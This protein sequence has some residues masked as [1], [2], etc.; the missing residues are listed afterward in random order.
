MFASFVKL[1]YLFNSKWLHLFCSIYYFEC[2]S[3]II[4]VIFV[5]TG[6]VAGNRGRYFLHHP[7]SDILC[8]GRHTAFILYWIHVRQ[9]WDSAIVCLLLL[10]T[11]KCQVPLSCSICYFCV[12][13]SGVCILHYSSTSLPA[14][15]Y[16]NLSIIRM[17]SRRDFFFCVQ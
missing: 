5:L 7:Y 16:P 4:L 11:C 17:R 15:L 6:W 9:V 14:S 10:Y 13:V 1:S 3:L 12:V 8:A 2:H